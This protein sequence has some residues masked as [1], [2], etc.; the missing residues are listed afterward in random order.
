MQTDSSQPWHDH[1]IASNPI[2]QSIAR[3]GGS[4]QPPKE[5]KVNRKQIATAYN[6]QTQKSP[7]TPH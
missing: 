3:P 6:L 7:F 1:S 2:D 4:K 5:K